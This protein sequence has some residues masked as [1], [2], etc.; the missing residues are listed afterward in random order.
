MSRV[1]LLGAEQAYVEAE[2][3]ALAASVNE[4]V[5]LGEL[6]AALDHPFLIAGKMQ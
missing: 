2:Q 3:A 1:R 5:A 4:R 6:E